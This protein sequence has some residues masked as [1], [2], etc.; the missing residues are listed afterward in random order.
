MTAEKEEAVIGST[1]QPVSKTASP[2]I[3]QSELLKQ[4][5]DRLL[6]VKFPYL[7]LFV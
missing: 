6:V 4:Q 1:L 3:R 7:E 5:M 2:E